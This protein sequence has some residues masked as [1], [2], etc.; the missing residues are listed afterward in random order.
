M[1]RLRGNLEIGGEVDYFRVEVSEPGLLLVYTTGSSHI[2][3]TLEDNTGDSLATDDDSGSGDNFR[4]THA[5][6]A[7][8]YY[9][10]VESDSG[11]SWDTGSY[12]IYASFN[13]D[14]GNT[15]ATASLL[16]LDSLLYGQIEPAGDVDYFQIEV[17]ES[18]VLTVYHDRQS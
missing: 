16:S 18:K 3:G 4:I 7:G 11:Y 6:S 8:T 13:S 14:H 12:T 10:K 17:S 9:V 5:V 15:R 1:N 2:K